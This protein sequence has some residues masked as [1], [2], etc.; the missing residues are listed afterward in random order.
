MPDEVSAEQSV[1]DAQRGSR[2]LRIASAPRRECTH[3][4]PLHLVPGFLHT[5]PVFGL[6]PALSVYSW[7]V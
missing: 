6:F 1:S 2:A 3:D 4:G 5:V 7:R